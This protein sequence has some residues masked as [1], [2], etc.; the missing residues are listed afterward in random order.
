MR[1]RKS[2]LVLVLFV[3]L[4]T[5]A[6][7]N[8]TYSKDHIEVGIRG[9]KSFLRERGDL[10][11]PNRL[12]CK[13]GL[14]SG[15]NVD[16]FH[17]FNQDFQ[18]GVSANYTLPDKYGYS[19]INYNGSSSTIISE[20]VK[21]GYFNLSTKAR[22]LFRGDKNFVPFFEGNV[23]Y[24][25]SP[26]VDDY[27]F[28][29]TPETLEYK[30]YNKRGGISYGVGVGAF[31]NK[32][33]KVQLGYGYSRFSMNA[34][35]NTNA[36]AS[37]PNVLY[38]GPDKMI[39]HFDFINHDFYISLAYVL[40]VG[41]QRTANIKKH[42]SNEN[43]NKGLSISIGMATSMAICKY[44]HDGYFPNDVLVYSNLTN[45][46]TTKEPTFVI[47]AEYQFAL[48]KSFSLGL[49]GN[50]YTPTEYSWDNRVEG[51]TEGMTSKKDFWYSYNLNSFTPYLSVSYVCNKISL[52]PYVKLKGGYN[53]VWYTNENKQGDGERKSTEIHDENG[54]Y[55]GLGFGC[56]FSQDWGL[57]F[58]TDFA[59][60]KFT[61]T[62]Q[63]ANKK[64]VFV[65]QDDKLKNN[66]ISIGFKVVRTF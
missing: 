37:D 33:V 19:Y 3:S 18:L 61:R 17:L 15:F 32:R 36:I 44:H 8:V 39:Q 27:V 9:I 20:N 63:A 31:L 24:T 53:M 38:S 46:F 25:F 5:I 14:P 41:S 60:S 43:A 64:G 59:H 58:S 16:Y 30:I 48:T 57:E 23:G 21:F 11:S 47:N 49:G 42:T 22:Y 52:S 29:D 55:A 1:L 45:M 4:P 6:Q 66:I 26:K 34:Y 54:Y 12:V 51:I 56:H 7:E 62:Y 28:F 13:K 35:V 40:S 50:Y 2:V 65:D 10:V